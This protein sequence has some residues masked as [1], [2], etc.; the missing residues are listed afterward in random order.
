[1]TDKLRDMETPNVMGYD[2]H[3]DSL[4]PIQR[5]I[6]L[7]VKCDYG[8]DPL[9]NDMHRMVPSGDIVTTSERM[10]RLAK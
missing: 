10:R 3:R 9:G 6:D 2:L 4:T 5:Y 7:T 1:M 8:A